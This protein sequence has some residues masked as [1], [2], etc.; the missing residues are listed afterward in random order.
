MTAPAAGAPGR[1]LVLN[2]GSSSIKFSLF[3]EDRR[4]LALEVRVPFKKV[5]QIHLLTADQP[6]SPGVWSFAS[7]VDKRD[8]VVE[9]KINRL[10]VS[11]IAVIE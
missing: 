4:D 6:Q 5:H 7:R 9:F 2:A 10:E 11:V 3:G 8:T 1:I